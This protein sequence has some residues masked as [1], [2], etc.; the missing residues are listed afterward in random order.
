MSSPSIAEMG[1]KQLSYLLDRGRLTAEQQVQVV[2]A[3]EATLARPTQ[4]IAAGAEAVR[5]DPPPDADA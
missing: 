2:T 3:L 5:T 4:A 1:I